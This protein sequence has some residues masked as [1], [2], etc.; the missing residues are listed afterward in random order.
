MSLADTRRVVCAC[1]HY[2]VFKEPET[3]LCLAPS[4]QVTPGSPLIGHFYPPLGEPY[5]VTTGAVNCQSRSP[6]DWRMEGGQAGFTGRFCR[7]GARQTN[8]LILGSGRFPVKGTAESADD[9][10]EKI[11]SL[12]FSDYE[13]LAL[14]CLSREQPFFL[15]RNPPI[16]DGDP[17]PANQPRCLAL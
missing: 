4:R 16:V 8:L 15:V 6:A 17:T 5:K 2:L 7:A 11:V 14:D 9:P 3:R 1:T 10:D 12:P 13:E